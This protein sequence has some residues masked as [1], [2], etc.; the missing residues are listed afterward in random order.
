MVSDGTS[1]MP[2]ESAPNRLIRLRRTRPTRTARV[3]R[4]AHQ[5]AVMTFRSSIPAHATRQL[6]CGLRAGPMTIRPLDL[7]VRL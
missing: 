7:G 2:G 6:R 1:D 3:H 4:R 5:R